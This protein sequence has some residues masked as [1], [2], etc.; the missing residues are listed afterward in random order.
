M[1]RPTGR[2]AA[3]AAAWLTAGAVGATAL[4]GFAFAAGTNDSAAPAAYP[5]ATQPPATD[6]P[7][8]DGPGGPGMKGRMGGPG[9]G[10]MGGVA[11]LGPEGPVL[12]GDLVVKDKDGKVVTIRVQ[13]GKVTAAGSDSITVASSDGYT[14]SWTLTAD[15]KIR[16]D[17]KDATAASLAVGDTVV[18]R[19]EVGSGNP[20]AKVVRAFSTE[21]LAKA[22]EK[23]SERQ[24]KR[25]DRKGQ[26]QP[27]PSTTEG[28]SL[29]EF[30]I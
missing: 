22:Q 1:N 14:S 28:A 29:S 12:H 11:R 3:I 21:G 4:T 19:G 27:A 26:N 20:T 9:M 6:A 23:R 17:M 24:Q 18:V 2:S 8:A 5:A 16:R 25:Q 30:N 10:G 15:T 7:P 13:S